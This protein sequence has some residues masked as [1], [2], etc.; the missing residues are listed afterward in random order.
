MLLLYLL[1]GANSPFW[2]WYLLEIETVVLLLVSL[3][4]IAKLKQNQFL[5]IL[6]SIPMVLV[7]KRRSNIWK[8]YF[9][10][11]Q[12][13]FKHFLSPM[14]L[15]TVTLMLS[16]WKALLLTFFQLKVSDSSLWIIV[17]IKYSYTLILRPKL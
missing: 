6:S 17:D 8:K 9:K 16:S 3:F 1:M 7:Q 2:S 12:K 5:I 13:L 4:V 11:H 14:L 10:H 15:Y